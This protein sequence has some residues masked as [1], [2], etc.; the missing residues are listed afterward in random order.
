MS[1]VSRA[2]GSAASSLTPLSASLCCSAWVMSDGHSMF[3]KMQL[4]A[5]V[6]IMALTNGPI[7]APFRP[8]SNL[9]TARAAIGRATAKCAI[10]KTTALIACLP[11][12]LSGPLTVYD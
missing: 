4:R 7:Q 9:N 12:A 11:A 1:D 10:Q 5:I 2:V 6:L 8:A 3:M